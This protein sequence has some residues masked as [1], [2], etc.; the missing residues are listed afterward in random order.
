[1]CSRASVGIAVLLLAACREET[2]VRIGAA[3]NWREAYG[4]MAKRGIDLATEEVNARGGVAG[5]T[6]SVV[7]LDDSSDGS[8]AVQ[9]AS[10]FLADPEILGVVGHIES[11]PMVAAARVY[12]RGLAAVSSTATAPALS[13]MSPWVF[14]VI[15]SDSVN[16]RDIANHARRMG[17]VRAAV[18]YENSSYGRGL[19]S[20]FARHFGGV[21]VSRDPIASDSTSDL[22]PNLT[23]ARL[24]RPDVV[25]VAG[26][27][28]SG[29][30]VLREAKR[31]GLQAA[32]IGGD[33]W[34]GVVAA[35]PLAEDVIVA[36]PFSAEDPRDDVQRFAMSFRRR[37]GAEPDANAA[38]AY[39]ATHLLARAID[40]AGA[41]RTAIRSWLG[42]RVG[43]GAFRGVTGSIQFTPSG[44]V[45]GK[46]FV[47]TRVRGGTLHVEA[48]GRGR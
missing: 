12:D 29:I 23:Y 21:V 35:G 3:G 19:A 26:T 18:L 9:V 43:E 28:A 11:D 33:G 1:M 2:S 41:S 4:I 39:D 31:Q 44:D 46:G 24:R 13:G 42:E 25:F 14:R 40:E 47:M 34:S 5:R 17:L 32:F 38:L 45:V 8:R 30:G 37:Y 36:T 22:E 16:G 10:Q 20:A 15:S 6:L 48:G 7:A 27:A